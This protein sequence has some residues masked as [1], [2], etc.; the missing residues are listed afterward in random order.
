M[1]SLEDFSSDFVFNIHI[2]IFVSQLRVL[3]CSVL[4][5]SSTERESCDPWEFL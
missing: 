4:H 3:V 1:F 5:A 2:F